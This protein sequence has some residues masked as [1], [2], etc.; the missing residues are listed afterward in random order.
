MR[1]EF[2]RPLP[3]HAELQALRRSRGLADGEHL[4]LIMTGGGGQDVAWPELLAG[5]PFWG[6]RASSSGFWGGAAYGADG[7]D[8]GGDSDP[9]LRVVVIAGN[10][11]KLVQRL[12]TALAP[13]RDDGGLGLLRGTNPL[14]TVQIAHDPNPPRPDK[15]YFIGSEEL[16]NLM[17]LASVCISKPGGGSTAELAYRGTPCVLDASKGAMHW[18]E[19]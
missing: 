10:N 14:V 2:I 19:L 15:P 11:V 8:G 1:P 5:S 18:E 3:S 9:P 13:V 17:D 4:V 7:G 16:T 6:N 12:S